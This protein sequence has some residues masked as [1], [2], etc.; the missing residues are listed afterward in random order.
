MFI[1]VC[2]RLL[3]LLYAHKCFCAVYLYVAGLN[4]LL[5]PS[6]VADLVVR[7]AWRSFLYVGLAWRTSAMFFF[8]FGA[9][10]VLCVFA[11]LVQLW[12]TLSA[13][14]AFRSS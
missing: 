4:A 12:Y 7:S 14:R 10:Q 6:G 8:R 1:F 11:G 13:P 3:V 9:A 2:S 5:G